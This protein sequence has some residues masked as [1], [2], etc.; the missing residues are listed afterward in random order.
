MRLKNKKYKVGDTIKFSTTTRDGKTTAT[1]K[2]KSVLPNGII[3][4]RFNGWDE[5]QLYSSSLDK[6]IEH[7]PA[8]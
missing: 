8:K 7:I 2:I 6:I 1:R 4:V 3:C 5:Y